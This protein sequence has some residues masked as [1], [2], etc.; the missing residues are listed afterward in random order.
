MGN[1]KTVRYQLKEEAH[2]SAHEYLIQYSTNKNEAT[3]DTMSCG[4]QE[5]Q[6][7]KVMQ[8]IKLSSYNILDSDQKS[9]SDSSKTALFLIQ[10]LIHILQNY[11]KAASCVKVK[12]NKAY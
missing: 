6:F 11:V 12:Q 1:S 4:T 8:Y 2:E 3:E 9:N 5:H 10:C 7:K